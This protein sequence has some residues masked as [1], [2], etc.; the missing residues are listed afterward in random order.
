M[1][2]FG[3]TAVGARA[4]GK[5]IVVSRAVVNDCG[6]AAPGC[7][8]VPGEDAAVPELLTR[9]VACPGMDTGGSCGSAADG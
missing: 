2:W 5:A 4:A 8:I 7:L 3:T 1:G 6:V 9:V